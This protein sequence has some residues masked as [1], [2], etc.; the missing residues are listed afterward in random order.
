[1]A[2]TL[3]ATVSGSSLADLCR[4]PGGDGGAGVDGDIGD[5]RD[6]GPV[7]DIGDG[8]CDGDTEGAGPGEGDC[9]GDGASEGESWNGVGGS[10]ELSGAI[11]CGDMPG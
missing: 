10:G 4:Y 5:G 7:G 1:M 3:E 8:S 9:G 6:D 11:C 2:C